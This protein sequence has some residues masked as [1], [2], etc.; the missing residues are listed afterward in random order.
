MMAKRTVAEIGRHF[1]IGLQ[2]VPEITDHDRRL[3][4]ALKPAGVILFK[5]NFHHDQPY[6]EWLEAHRRLIDEVRS[7]IGR[8][9]LLVAIDHEGGR[10]TRTPP[11]ITR[12][13]AARHQAPTARA[14]GHAMAAEL[15]SLGINLSFAPV[16][17]V[18]SNPANPVIGDRAFGRTFEDAARAGLELMAGLEEG[19]LIACP[20]HFPGHG[21]TRTD[22]H[23]GLPVLDLDLDALRKRELVPFQRA[24]AAGAR[25]LMTAHILFPA[26]DA[27]NPATFSPRIIQDLLR[28]EMGYGGVVVTDDLGMHAV[29]P[30]LE[31]PDCAPRLIAAGCD[32]IML[33]SHFADTGKALRL[34][35]DLAAADIPDAVLAASAARIDKLL[36]QAASHPV[37]ALDDATFA[38]H[39]K[40]GPLFEGQTVQVV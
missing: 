20:K 37:Q 36:A 22:S 17:D 39:R 27:D 19:G 26:I 32:L 18:D 3:L 29:S 8:E 30:L 15:A 21:D 4:A 25:L 35:H 14:V 5:K 1:I 7:V 33:C 31:R 28:S 11:P 34:A 9:R 38:R 24:I 40:A 13:A 23:V 10:V 2:P 12:F 16:M 6:P